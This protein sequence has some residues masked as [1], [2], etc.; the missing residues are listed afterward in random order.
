MKHKIHESLK[1]LCR[2]L[3]AGLLLC[4]M[5]CGCALTAAA[6]Y[7]I[8]K[9]DR[10]MATNNMGIGDWDEATHRQAEAGLAAPLDE[11][12]LKAANP[13][14]K[15]LRDN[16]RIYMISDIAG[17]P[18]IANEMD[19]YR[20]MY[21]L[22]GLLGAPE[23][24]DLRL[25][26]VLTSDRM[27]V[28]VFQQVYEGLTVVASIAKLVTDAQGNVQA[29]VSS[30][31]AALPQGTGAAQINQAEAEAVVAGEIS[32]AGNRG[33]VLA[34]YTTRAI[35]P[36]DTDIDS[37]E[38]APDRLVW[39]V[40][41]HNP[42]FEAN[43]SSDLPYLAHYVGLDGEYIRCNPVTAPGIRAD[44]AGY[45]SA[46]A[47]DFMVEAE[48]RGEVTDG[49]GEKSE[50]TVPVMRD[51][52][53]GVW[54]LGDPTRKI[55]VADF[56]KLVY[57]DGEMQMVASMENEGWNDEDLITYANM[58][59]VWDFYANLGW[60]GPDG[61]GTPILLLRKMVMEDG[62]SIFNAAYCGMFEGWQC[63]AF[64]E[65]SYLG[66]SLD[67]I[68]HE[69]THCVTSTVMDTN[70]YQDDLGAINEAMSD[71][72]GNLCEML[73]GATDDHEWLINEDQGTVLRSMLHPHEYGQPEYV[74]DVYYAPHADTPND[75]ND[76]GGVH[77]NSSI[78]NRI[79]ARLCEEAGL[80]LQDAVDYWMTVAFLLTPRTDYVQLADVMLCAAEVSGRPEMLEKLG[81]M[82]E[83]SRM[84]AKDVP[85]KLPDN[86]RIVS[87]TLPDTEAFEDDN[88][89]LQAVQVDT[90]E[91]M[92]R[93]GRIWEL[94]QTVFDFGE[95]AETRNA[96][97]HDLLE[98]LNLEQLN[99]DDPENIGTEL[100]SALM[101]GIVTEHFSWRSVRGGSV[102]M[103]VQKRPTVYVLMNIDPESMDLKGMAMLLNDEWFD[104]MSL[105]DAVDDDG[106]IR[107]EGEA[108]MERAAE[109]LIDQL[110]AFIGG[111]EETADEVTLSAAG[112]ENVTLAMEEIPEENME[113]NM[114]E[115]A[116]A[117]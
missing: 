88:W 28:Y 58:I 72:M 106:S 24:I 110:M 63:F 10:L 16:G 18:A 26:S 117:A 29:V 62:E 1:G 116:D 37:D 96:K 112:L 54:Y 113:E 50:L 48:W 91:V 40:Y 14:V 101:K 107:P 103:V 79:A 12:A 70:L 105:M 82:I 13:G 87:L 115:E 7:G 71:I 41:S 17:L 45:P 85:E 42:A 84:T 69:Y 78:L 6:E 21:S 97:I 90:G 47:F 80:P 102:T 11:Q 99:L 74:W 60:K 32:A 57:G 9:E 33:A 98:S 3:L 111:A 67:V 68:A 8:Q 92:A 56:A 39:V 73:C 30:L 53:T 93:L 114:V 52:R 46:Q 34:E 59:K 25:W 61:I 15:L 22:V 66:Q 5:L 31:S 55:A 2:R 20:V 76:R 27:R 4:A 109:K 35:I 36:V 108:V 43:A 75:V 77:T 65:N 44:R 95:K 23:G 83:E 104:L 64:G 94:V 51:S 100:L 89:F 86:Q 81:T 19:A 49:N 38:V